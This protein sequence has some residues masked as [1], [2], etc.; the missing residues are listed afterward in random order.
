MTRAAEDSDSGAQAR[1]K[2]KEGRVDAIAQ[3]RSRGDGRVMSDAAGRMHTQE[4]LMG[5]ALEVRRVIARPASRSSPRERITRDAT[6]GQTGL[7]Q[8]KRFDEAAQVKGV[9]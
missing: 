1:K 8:A 7:R 5:R 9:R 3:E 4:D 2:I 6:T